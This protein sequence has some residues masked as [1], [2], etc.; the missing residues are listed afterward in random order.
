MSTSR[1][2]CRIAIVFATAV[3][4][5]ASTGASSVRAQGSKKAVEALDYAATYPRPTLLLRIQGMEREISDQQMTVAFTGNVRVTIG[6]TTISCD[7]LVAYYER[8]A[9]SGGARTDGH[10]PNGAQ[11]ISKLVAKGSVVLSYQDQSAMA[12]Y[13]FFDLDANLATL[14]GAIMIAQGQHVLPNGRLIV[15]LATG[16]ARVEAQHAP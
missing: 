15:N 1:K 8:G 13:G 3:A 2:V 6:D 12:D 9:A 14:A 4:V 5:G 11:W 16:V 7:S 10:G